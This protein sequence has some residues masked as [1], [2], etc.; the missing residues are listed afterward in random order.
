[1]INIKLIFLCLI[2]SFTKISA[3]EFIPLWPKDNM[4]NSKGIKVEEVIE[5]EHILQVDTPVFYTFFT[6][7]KENSG[8]A[9]LICPSGEYQRLT[10][11]L[12]GFQLAKWFNTLGIN[13]F[14]LKYRLPHSPDLKVRHEAPL[15]DAQRAM[16]IIRANAEKWSIQADKIGVMSASA[17]AHLA[18][19][20][21]THDE[22]VSAIGDCLDTV[23]F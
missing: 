8:C 13:A 6:S 16:R 5:N 10:Y 17:G 19:T 20:L 7:K 21:G 3:Q 9:V 14:V 18:S 1:M 2:L 12:G 11:I 15:Q 22:D 4:P 23:S